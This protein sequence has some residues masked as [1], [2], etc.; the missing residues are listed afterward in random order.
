MDSIYRTIRKDFDFLYHYGFSFDHDEHH[1]V[2]PSVVF[3]D[4]IRFL[5]IGMHYEDGKMFAILYNSKEQL[6][7]T[8]LLDNINLEGRKYKEQVQQVRE[9]LDIYIR[10]K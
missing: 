8:N 6:I 4:G 7:G 3:S 2:M 5:Q 1:Y 9:Y 10:S